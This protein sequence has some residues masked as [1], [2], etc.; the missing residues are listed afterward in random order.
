MKR[1]VLLLLLGT[2][3]FL[4]GE[5]SDNVSH[6]RR[7]LAENPPPRKIVVGREKILPLSVKGKPCVEIVIAANAPSVVRLAA[8]E[9]RYFLSASLGAKVEIRKAPGNAATKIYLGDNPEL[10]KLGV[11]PEKMWI[12]SFIIRSDGNRIFIA[13]KDTKV[14]FGQGLGDGDRGTLFG[15]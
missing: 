9:L 11:D 12:E 7:V 13:G 1:S 10:R 2:A 5:I 14:N 3:A 6:A 4:W 15:V 8:Q